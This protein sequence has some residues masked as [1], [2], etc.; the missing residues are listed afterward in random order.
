VSGRISGTR[1]SIPDLLRSA[2]AHRPEQEIDALQ[3]AILGG[4]QPGWDVHRV[5]GMLGAGG[6]QGERAQSELQQAAAL[7]LM[8]PAFQWR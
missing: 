4:A 1:V 7:L 2:H 6:A 3:V 8:S 5:A